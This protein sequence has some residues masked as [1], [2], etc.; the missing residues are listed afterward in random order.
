MSDENTDALAYVRETYDVPARLG[1]RI[2]FDGMFPPREGTIVGG[3]AAHL[4][5]IFDGEA[6]VCYL[7][8]T[9]KVEYLA[10]D[11]AS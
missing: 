3:R 2:S 6:G 5:V 8:P 4:K 9:W 10:T 1:Q 7:H 11:G